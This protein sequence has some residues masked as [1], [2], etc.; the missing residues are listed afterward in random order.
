MECQS[1]VW[2]I[3]SRWTLTSVPFIFNFKAY[4][5]LLSLLIYLCR[6]A[7]IM[8][9][10]LAVDSMS[11]EGRG[12]NMRDTHEVFVSHT[13]CAWGSPRALVLGIS[14]PRHLHNVMRPPQS[15]SMPLLD[16]LFSL[17]REVRGAWSASPVTTATVPEWVARRWPPASRAGRSGV[18]PPGGLLP[19]HLPLHAQMFPRRPQRWATHSVDA[20]RVSTPRHTH[21]THTHTQ[22][23]TWKFSQSC[24][25]HR[26]TW[27]VCPVHT[28]TRG[29][30]NSVT[31]WRR[32]L[33]W[34]H[35]KDNNQSWEWGGGAQGGQQ[36][37]GGSRHSNSKRS[38]V[39]I[40]RTKALWEYLNV[41]L[42]QD[43]V[44]VSKPVDSGKNYSLNIVC[45]RKG[46]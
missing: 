36:L 6:N 18:A 38:T 26:R 39:P 15:V 2:N 29:P 44:Q 11:A 20:T 34:R 17:F 35:H 42:T 31:F 21:T 12:D 46:K 13:L 19:P 8:G 1:P 24:Y 45:G 22:P 30:V 7:L 9:S 41:G 14:Q 28:H 5:S 33:A 43:F 3:I 23:A 32:G 16:V 37:Q 4:L 25:L 10:V 27:H 40:L